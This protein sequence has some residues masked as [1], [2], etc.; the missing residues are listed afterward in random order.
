MEITPEVQAQLDE[1]KE[2]CPFCKITKG[3]IPASIAYDDKLMFGILDINPWTTG[4]ILLYPKEHYPIMPYIPVKT[5]QHIFGNLPAMIKALKKS[6]LCSGANVFIANGGVAG[7][8][9]PHFLMHVL[10]REKNDGITKFAFNKKGKLDESKNKQ[11]NTMLAQ[12]MP[13]MLKN[14]FKRTPVNWQTGNTSTIPEHL[15]FIKPE[16]ILYQDEKVICI[17]PENQMCTGH[18]TIYSKEEPKLFE[19]LNFESGSHIFYVASYAATAAFEGLGAHGSN[20]ILKT[21]KCEDNTDEKL[22][23]HILPRYQDDGLDLLCKPIDN[24]P[25][26]KELASKIKDAMFLVE[27]EANNR[28][29]QKLKKIEPKESK[30]LTPEQEEIKKAIEILKNN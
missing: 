5:F 25:D 8:Q 6:I 4:H 11:I 10:P 30:P 24:K 1:Q 16:Q 26:F 3:E 7:Q 13:I 18:M 15:N 20:I 9:S 17:A 12:N 22:S 2:Q 29:E 21:G 23:L 28:K 14:H 19:K 27:H